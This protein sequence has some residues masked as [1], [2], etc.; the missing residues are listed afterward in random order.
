MDQLGADVDAADEHAPLPVSPKMNGA[1]PSALTT[2]PNAEFDEVVARIIVNPQTALADLSNA[3]LRRESD[4]STLLHVIAG[5]SRCQDLVTQLLRA[6]V[7]ADVQEGQIATCQVLLAHGATPDLA[8]NGLTPLR[9][10]AEVGNAEMT[11][12]LLAQPGAWPGKW[13]NDFF[14]FLLE[15]TPDAVVTYLD[16]FAT[17]LNHSKRGYVAVK[18]SGLRA[19]YGEPDVPV[20]ST[21]LALAVKSANARDILS[22]RVMKYVVRTKWKAFAKSMFRREFSAYCTLLVAYYVP[23]VWADPDWIQ[24]TSAFDYWVA[25]SRAVSWGC[26]AYLLL[27]VERNEFMGGSAKSYFYSFWN[28]LNIVTYVATMA[29]VPLE[30]VVALTDVRNSMLALIIVA[31]WLNLLQFLQMS[32]ESGL[33]I[34]MMSHMVKDV[35]RFLLLYAVFLFG[36]SGAFYILLRGSAGFEN[37]TNAFLTVFLLLFGQLTFDTFNAT[38]GWIWHASVG[39]LMVHL[40]SVV[41]VLL[42]IL[43]AMMAT[44]YADVWES[45]EA[46]ALQSH[47]QAIIR[48]EK[49]LGKRERERV[50][51]RLC[52]VDMRR[53]LSKQQTVAPKVV[54]NGSHAELLSER[55]TMK[56]TMMANISATLLALPGT[57]GARTAMHKAF[58]KLP[59]L[60]GLGGG[61]SPIHPAATQGLDAASAIADS[62]HRSGAP[63]GPKE[64]HAT[65]FLEA[66]IET[67]NLQLTALEESLFLK[68][69][70]D[71]DDDDGG[72]GSA[73][74]RLG[75]LV[76]GIRYEPPSKKPKGEAA[77]SALADLQAQVEQ[78]SK[79]VTDMQA[80]MQEERANAVRPTRLSPRRS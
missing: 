72:P 39:L 7:P 15:K 34:A 70:L 41:I 54:S 6:G 4:G 14:A 10:A 48:M 25:L 62:K 67:P 26:C 74:N 76:D 68:S 80:L 13:D 73:A 56:R 40:V 61:S 71:Q 78:L 64:H 66:L 58:G 31:L 52:R 32:T 28:L 36:F 19:I 65:T 42:N 79:V 69:A 23:T 21:A 5:W 1:A 24:L 49:S 11:K 22:H 17:V 50:C 45:A 38:T 2:V 43:I 30:F 57:T 20:E 46:E 53:F 55:S 9:A 12:W 37:F 51:E 47:A 60:G 27:R 59:P 44:T 75:V 18:Y 63:L 35:Y 8:V 77:Q 33:L 3:L 29:T 16:A